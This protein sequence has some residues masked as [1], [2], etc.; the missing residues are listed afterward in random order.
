LLNITNV[1]LI[2]LVFQATHMMQ[3][4]A[5]GDGE[6]QFVIGIY[7]PKT[8][9]FA[10]L[11]AAEFV[12]KSGGP[13]YGQLSSTGGTAEGG[14]PGDP[15]TIHVSWMGGNGIPPAKSC[16]GG[17]LLT[18]LRDLRFD[19]RLVPLDSKFGP[20]G[21]LVETP[22]AEYVTLLIFLFL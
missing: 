10:N 5:Q 12:D 15:R 14:A 11:T 18:A 7:D 16:L 3:V 4:D 20:Q 9:T 13:R 22:I 19:P 21:M 1:P 8:E 6:A 17:G 2:P